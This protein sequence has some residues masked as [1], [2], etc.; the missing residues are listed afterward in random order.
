MADLVRSEI[1]DAATDVAAGKNI[2]QQHV[3]VTVG[4]EAGDRTQVRLAL[5]EM[6]VAKTQRSQDL[7]S[8]AVMGLTATVVIVTVIMLQSLGG[9]RQETR[10]ALS[11]LNEH[12]IRLESKFEFHDRQREQSAARLGLP[13]HE[14]P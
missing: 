5:L 2:D 7:L 12:L 1:G 6:Q 4:G 10:D 3:N 13:S 11:T 14:R 9:M 8:Y